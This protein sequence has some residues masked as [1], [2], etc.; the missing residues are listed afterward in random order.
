M[1]ARAMRVSSAPPEGPPSSVVDTE[2]L[3]DELDAGITRV[4]ALDCCWAGGL[5]VPPPFGGG[6]GGEGR[7]GGGGGGGR[8]G[9]DPV[10]IARAEDDASTRAAR[11]APARGPRL[12]LSMAAVM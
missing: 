2:E 7:G 5:L 6:G 8:R 3:E 1:P 9:G 10:S 4:G 12:P 11:T